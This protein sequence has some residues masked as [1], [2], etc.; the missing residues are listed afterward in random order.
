M[1]EELIELRNCRIQNKIKTFFP[2]LSWE[3]KK[4]ESW[5]V[6]GPN[7]GG[8]ADFV[9]ALAGQLS[10]VPIS[11]S[12]DDYKNCFEKNVAVVS[13]EE[14]AFLIEEERK[15]IRDRVLNCRT[16]SRNTQLR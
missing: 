6:I 15:T 11:G 10:F 8:K 1:S 3:F 13:L 4:G 2:E 16:I 9:K 5:L 7:G 12:D 14:A